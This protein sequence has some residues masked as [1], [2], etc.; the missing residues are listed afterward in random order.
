MGRKVIFFEKHA[1]PETTAGEGIE[2]GI[3]QRPS[4]ASSSFLRFLVAPG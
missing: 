2:I 4:S 3:M 1:D